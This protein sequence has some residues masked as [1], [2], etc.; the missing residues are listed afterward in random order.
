MNSMRFDAMMHRAAGAQLLGNVDANKIFLILMYLD[1]VI[2]VRTN[3]PECEI[4]NILKKQEEKCFEKL[5]NDKSIF[6]KQRFQAGCEG[7]WDNLTC[8]PFSSFGKTVTLPCPNVIYLLAQKEGFISR[9]C[10]SEGWSDTFPE[11]RTACGYDMDDTTNDAKV[12]M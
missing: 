3:P 10:T 9:N 4:P 6:E 1:S 8:W 7:M 5:T 2:T 11:Y 12:C